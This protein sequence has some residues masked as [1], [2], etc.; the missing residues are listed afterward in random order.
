M[1]HGNTD[2]NWNVVC[3][4]ITNTKVDIEKNGQLDTVS[5][6]MNSE[7]ISQMRQNMSRFKTSCE[8][9]SHGKMSVSYNFI[10]IQEPLTSLSF[11]E[12]NGYHVEPKDVRNLIDSYLQ[13]K[14][15]DHIFVCIKLGDDAH[16][17]DIPVYD[18]IGLGGMD[19]LGIGFS[20]IRLPNSNKSY[21]YKYDARVNT[22]PEEVFIHEFLHS[23][24]RI[25][26]EYGYERPAL[27]DYEKYGYKDEKLIGLKKWYQDYMNCEIKTSSGNIG[28]NKDIYG[29]KPNNEENFRFTYTLNEFNEPEN[30]IEEIKM[31]IKK[32]I[33]NIS[34]LTMKK[35]ENAI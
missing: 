19:Y 23:L 34:N 28:L 9:L 1:E 3:F 24:E 16:Q 12:E 27:H 35:E 10:T 11:D 8:E 31:I 5:L 4:V 14:N 13:Q 22:F 21:T 26:E 29:L 17:N 33:N 6:S 2:T 18:W 20:N 30:K 25:S 15:Y 32:A 7:E